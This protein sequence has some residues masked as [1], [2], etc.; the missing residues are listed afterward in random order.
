MTKLSDW[1]GHLYGYDRMR[2]YKEQI[3]SIPSGSSIPSHEDKDDRKSWASFNGYKTPVRPWTHMGVGSYG[4]YNAPGE[5]LVL[6]GNDITVYPNSLLV[7]PEGELH[8]VPEKYRHNTIEL[9]NSY[10][11]AVIR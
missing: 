5:K 9:P 7:V 1:V 3:R 4:N 6:G 10:G 11:Y 2:E 8:Q